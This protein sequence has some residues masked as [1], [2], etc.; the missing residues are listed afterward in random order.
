M[1][2]GFISVGAAV[3]VVRGGT[4]ADGS[5]TVHAEPGEDKITFANDV[6]SWILAR[7]SVGTQGG[8]DKRPKL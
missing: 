5:G 3:F 2:L 1:M 8:E 7:S 6:A 4:G